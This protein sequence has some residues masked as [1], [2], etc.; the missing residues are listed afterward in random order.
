MVRSAVLDVDSTQA[1]HLGNSAYTSTQPKEY[2]MKTITIG[3]IDFELT[4]PRKRIAKPVTGF[5]GSREDIFQWYERPSIYK[6]DI[7]HDWLDWAYT[8]DGVIV[9]EICSANCNTFSIHGYYIADDGK[10]YNL[11]IT[12]AHNRAILCQGRIETR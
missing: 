7:W 9:F 2:T 10:C 3:N 6:V 8:T 11:W 5:L 1:D 12:K 4:I